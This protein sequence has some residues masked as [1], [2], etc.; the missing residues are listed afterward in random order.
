MSNSYG[1]M[2]Q[3]RAHMNALGHPVAGD[4]LYFQK[5]YK[6]WQKSASR[7]FLHSYKLGFKDI[8]EKWVEYKIELPNELKKILKEIK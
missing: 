1:R 3:I 5:Q 4:N 8:D 6:K 7:L 2:H